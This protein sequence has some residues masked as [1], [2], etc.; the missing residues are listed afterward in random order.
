VL[1]AGADPLEEYVVRR[2]DRDVAV[3]TAV[4]AARV[5]SRLAAGLTSELGAGELPDQEPGVD[6]SEQR[7]D[8]RDLDVTRLA[9]VLAPPERADDGRGRGGRPL[10]R[11]HVGRVPRGGFAGDRVLAHARAPGEPGKVILDA[12]GVRALEPLLGT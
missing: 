5:G 2:R 7:L 6:V 8:A 11:R 3:R 9:A 12:S 10:H 1:D 4:A